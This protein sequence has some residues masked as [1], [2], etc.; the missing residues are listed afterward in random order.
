MIVRMHDMLT[1]R[2]THDIWTKFP[3]LGALWADAYGPSENPDMVYA[4][5][6]WHLL[7][8]E[9]AGEA[10]RVVSNVGLQVRRCFA[11]GTPVRV[12]AIGGVATLTSHQGRGMAAQLMRAAHDKMRELGLEFGLLQC[13]DKRITFYEGLGWRQARVP[14]VFDQPDGSQH[15]CDENPMVLLLTARPWPA[16]DIDMNGLPW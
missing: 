4:E 11:G 5:S 10:Q 16:G 15:V 13:P 12:G 2:R 1:V 14:M 9:G 8:C 7:I 6:A 3:S